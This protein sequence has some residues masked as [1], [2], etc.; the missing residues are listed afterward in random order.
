MEARHDHALTAVPLTGLDR[1][2][3]EHAFSRA[4]GAPLVPGNDVR[5]LLDAGE[6]FPAWLSAIRGAQR[7]IVFENY[8]IEADEVGLAFA[9][10]LA[11]RARAGVKVR[12]IRDWYGS[13]GG[14]PRRY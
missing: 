1:N 6:N 8:I 14:A 5:I 11:E 3:V 10:A 13:F 9:D 4:A 2:M 12:L 7:S